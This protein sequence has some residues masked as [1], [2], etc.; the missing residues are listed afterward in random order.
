MAYPNQDSLLAAEEEFNYPEFPGY[1]IHEQNWD[2][3]NKEEERE[4]LIC[5]QWCLLRKDFSPLIVLA[6]VKVGDPL[7][8]PLFKNKNFT[9]S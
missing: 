1:Y 9:G 8:G 6:K 7:L 4:I 3:E 2:S 5:Y